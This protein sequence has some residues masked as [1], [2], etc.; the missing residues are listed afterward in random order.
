MSASRLWKS[1]IVRAGKMAAAGVEVVAPGVGAV[2]VER[3]WF[4]VPPVE[5]ARRNAA[6][7]L[8]DPAGEAWHLDVDGRRVVGRAWG[9][10]P[11]VYLVHGWGGWGTQLVAFV[12]PLVEAGFRVVSY[13]AL[14]HGDSAPGALGRRRSSLVE[15][16]DV[17]V[18]VAEEHGPAAAVVAHS[19]GG[20]ATALALKA[21]LKAD[22]VVLVA[23]AADPSP[24]L[25]AL[26]RGLGFGRRVERRV[27]ARVERRVGVTIAELNVPRI[28]AGVA[29][30]P[31]LVVHDR[32]DREV[33][34]SDGAAIAEAW[35]EST[36]VSTTGLGHRRILRDPVVTAEVASFV[37]TTG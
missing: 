8:G 15:L 6:I 19:L 24:Y 21:G 30:P 36:L 4:R 34:W 37:H 22:R 2:I 28:A 11:P 18:A 29:T 3:L 17:L 10:G 20:A 5:V 7:P 26:V 13:D 12:Q 25:R 31:V 23:P 33:A 27:R 1:T 9:D 14:S 35:P 16:A 32:D